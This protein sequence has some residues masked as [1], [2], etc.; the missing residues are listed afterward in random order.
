[1]AEQQQQLPQYETLIVS[2]FILGSSVRSDR[3]L[4]KYVAF[5]RPLINYA[6]CRKV[7][8]ISPEVYYS[9]IADGKEKEM[10]A[11]VS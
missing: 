4:E 8:F 9:H 3:P 2:A 10:Q 6:G 1:M 5:G 11:G 7:V